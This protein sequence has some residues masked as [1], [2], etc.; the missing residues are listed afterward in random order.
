MP[1]SQ[2]PQ[3]P[4]RVV[5]ADGMP[6]FGKFAGAAQSI[7]WSGLEPPYLRG[8][9][10]RR[11]HHKRWRLV[12]LATERVFCSVGMVD[13]GWSN[14]AFAH[15]FERGSGALLA[16]FVQDSAP[17]LA[18]YV[19]DCPL[20]GA[21]SH[22]SHAGKRID[23]RHDGASGHFRLQ[24]HCDAFEIDAELDA[25]RAGPALLAIGPIQRG[26]VHATQKSAG[27]ALQGAIA[28]EGRR[29]DLSGG[30]GWSDYSNGFLAHETA[31]RWACAQS[32]TIGFNLQAGYFGHAENALWLDGNLYP[33]GHA[34]FDFKPGQTLDAW[35]IYTEDGLLD[36]EFQP[37]GEWRQNRNILLAA[38]RHVQASGTYIGWV[39][40][41]PEA[42][43][44]DIDRLVGMAEDHFSRW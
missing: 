10:W 11:F 6:H 22:F 18:S 43:A 36:V 33:L 2:L 32:L 42:P 1:A 37:E 21:D 25:S 9:W 20:A 14:T 34:R 17:G 5:D 44:H 8:T 4:L 7:D 15:V 12:V 24:L 19:G 3:A 41:A 29:Y 13:L 31:W 38:S 30:V 35:H 16:D 27:M 28:L 23:F 39:R 40:T 26:S